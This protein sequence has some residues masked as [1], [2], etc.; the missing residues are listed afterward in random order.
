MKYTIEQLAEW[1]Q[2]TIHLE[3]LAT[4]YLDGMGIK[5]DRITNFEIDGSTLSFESEYR[6]CGSC[7]TDY[8]THTVQLEDIDSDYYQ[9]YLNRLIGEREDRQREAERAKRKAQEKSDLRKLAALQA[10][11][12]NR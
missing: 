2:I 4:R 12:P 11:Y 5:Y 9:A 7:G 3:E 8:D 6:H 1:E 10:K